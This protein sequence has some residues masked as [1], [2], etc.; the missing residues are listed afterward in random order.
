MG[1]GYWQ[2]LPDVGKVRLLSI[3]AHDQK[4]V[5]DR[6]KLGKKIAADE[7][8]LPPVEVPVPAGWK[9]IAPL[10]GFLGDRCRRPPISAEQAQAKLAALLDGSIS[11]ALEEV[12]GW[13]GQD[14]SVPL[15]F[16]KRI[17]RKNSEAKFW[18]ADG[19]IFGQSEKGTI[20]HASLL[21]TAP[22]HWFLQRAHDPVAPS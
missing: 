13:P 11:H 17:P 10:L 21:F 9:V 20:P 4:Q 2:V 1:T 16:K 18:E 19:M 12:F 22:N 14:E 3:W 7:R 6:D 5:D 8:Y 15:V